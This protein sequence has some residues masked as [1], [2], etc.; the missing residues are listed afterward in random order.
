MFCPRCSQE[1]VSEELRF[2]SRC[3]LPLGLISEVVAHEGFLPQ[4][5]AL[6]EKKK[7]WTR[8]MG[9]KIGAAWLLIFL[10]FAPLLGLAD[11]D[12]AA[13]ASAIVGLLGGF[14]IMILSWMFLE[15]APK[16]MS[17]E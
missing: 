12:D 14:L 17:V 6:T 10:C 2:C 7:F 8:Q 3:G 9:V 16:P 11:L 5:A 1:Q 13:G 4:L 15:S